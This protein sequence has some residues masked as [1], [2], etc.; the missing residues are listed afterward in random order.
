MLTRYY[1]TS[2]ISRLLHTF[3]ADISSPKPRRSATVPI[4]L[5]RYADYLT[6]YQD[7]LSV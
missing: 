7:S 2:P 1:D 4:D 3:R 5:H 6:R